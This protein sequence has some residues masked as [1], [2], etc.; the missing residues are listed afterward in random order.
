[1]STLRS[2]T[3]VIAS[4]SGT[5]ATLRPKSATP[6]D[7]RPALSLS[8]DRGLQRRA[9][10][11]HKHTKCTPRSPSAGGRG[12]PA[13]VR[14]ICA[15]PSP[16]HREGRSPL[17]MRGRPRGPARPDH[18]VIGYARVSTTDQDKR[19]SRRR[20]A[21]SSGWR[22]SSGTTTEGREALRRP[23]DIVRT[24][25]ARGAVLKATEQPIDT[26]TAK[27]LLHGV[28]R[29]FVGVSAS[30]ASFSQSSASRS[31]ECLVDGL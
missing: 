22:R 17:R 19:R 31:S 23:S 9:D 16:R 4:A 30:C 28:K 12:T 26:P 7:P 1:M 8:R 18:D 5:F 25:R 27:A 14:P 24:V 11:A 2:A 6:C 29:R 3:A 20:V 21:K 15:S 13:P 10:A